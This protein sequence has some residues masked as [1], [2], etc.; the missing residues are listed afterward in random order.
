MKNTRRLAAEKVIQRNIRIR[1]VRARNSRVF[2]VLFFWRWPVLARADT[3]ISQKL[4]IIRGLLI[5]SF[6]RK[7]LIE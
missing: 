2:L 4:R 3:G 7:D 6:R 5:L 1:R